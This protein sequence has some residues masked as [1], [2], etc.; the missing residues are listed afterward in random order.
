MDCCETVVAELSTAKGY[1]S[2]VA[3]VEDVLEVRL[4]LQLILGMQWMGP[5][6][7]NEGLM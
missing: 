5:G 4:G 2:T 7:E 6:S 1:H 3:W